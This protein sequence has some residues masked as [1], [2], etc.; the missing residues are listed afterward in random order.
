MV[1][2]IARSPRPCEDARMRVIIQGYDLPGR[3]FCGPAG[4]P[5]LDVRVGVQIRKDHEQLVPGDAVATH[6][7]IDVTVAEDA[8][9]GLDFRGSAVHGKRSDR[10]IYLSWGN[11]DVDGHFHMFRRAKLMLNA[12]IPT[13]CAPPTTAR[14]PCTPGSG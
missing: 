10:F 14:A 8:A 2:G 5:Y 12:S 6:W 11:V 7:E 3:S 1:R 13:S 4:E 9:G